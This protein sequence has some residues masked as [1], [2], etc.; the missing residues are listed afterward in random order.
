MS[1]ICNDT[2]LFR[3]DDEIHSFERDDPH[4]ALVPQDRRLGHKRTVIESDFNRLNSRGA[5][6]PAIG[7]SEAVSRCLF[8]IEASPGGSASTGRPAFLQARKPPLMTATRI[9]F[10]S[11]WSVCGF[12]LVEPLMRIALRSR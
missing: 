11:R 7:Y 2:S 8:Q 5:H 1:R 4:E 10:F 12:S 6:A 9:P 3:I